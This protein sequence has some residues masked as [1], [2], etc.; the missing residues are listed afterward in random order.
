MNDSTTLFLLYDAKEAARDQSSVYV[1]TNFHQV[2]EEVGDD[3][4]LKYG[5]DTIL[6]TSSEGSLTNE[7]ITRSC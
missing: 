2:C 6:I 7:L 1:G 3:S 5:S 4:F